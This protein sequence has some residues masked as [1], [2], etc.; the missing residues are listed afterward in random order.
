D[1]TSHQLKFAGFQQMYFDDSFPEEY[2]IRPRE[3]LK[4]R[5]VPM[6][7]SAEAIAQY[8]GL[9]KRKGDEARRDR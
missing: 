9:E 4:N 6:E 5:P 3:E 1:A 7:A 8:L 2:E